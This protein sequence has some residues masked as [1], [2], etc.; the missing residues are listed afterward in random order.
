MDEYLI[1]NTTR[2]Q[3]ERIVS[4]SLGNIDG[5]CD[6]CM[7]RIVDMYDDY[8]YGKKELA[9]INASFHRGYI[10]GDDPAAR[11]A[12]CCNIHLP[13]PLDP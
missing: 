11:E 12:P 7:A 13:S 4:E 5:Q 2:E 3:R 6:G 1:K 10:H 9:E 8:I